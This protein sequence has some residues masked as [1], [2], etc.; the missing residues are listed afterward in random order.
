MRWKVRNST[1]NENQ[2]SS[3]KALH[4]PLF[5]YSCLVY[6]ITRVLCIST[7]FISPQFSL[8]QFISPQF[9]SPQFT[10]PLMSSLLQCLRAVYFTTRVYFTSPLVCNQIN[11]GKNE[12]YILCKHLTTFF[13][14]TI[15]AQTSE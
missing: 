10:L 4:H 14:L 6:F 5:R 11:V 8:P 2:D 15:Y 12:H 3:G 1:L 9:I 7:Q 13:S